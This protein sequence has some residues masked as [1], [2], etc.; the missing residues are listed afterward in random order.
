MDSSPES[1]EMFRSAPDAAANLLEQVDQTEIV[2]QLLLSFTA[3]S[4]MHALAQDMS[5]SVSLLKMFSS[6]DSMESMTQDEVETSSQTTSFCIVLHSYPVCI[7][8]PENVPRAMQT[9]AP[10]GEILRA[11]PDCQM[12]ALSTPG[13]VK[14]KYF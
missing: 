14:K 4:S 13:Q 2:R 8:D 1:E 10:V 12:R 11:F 3:D 9:L 6:P 5:L 7:L